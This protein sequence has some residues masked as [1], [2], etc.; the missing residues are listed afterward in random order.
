MPPARSTPP[1]PSTPLLAGF[2]AVGGTLGALLGGGTGLVT[3]PVLDR[4]TTLPRATAHGTATFP[5]MAVALI[6]SLVYWLRGGAIDLAAGLPLMA[7]GVLGAFL[8]ARA[9]AH[10]PE[11][12]LRIVFI[13]VLVVAGAKLLTDA[14]GADP[15]DG[16]GLVTD[17][18]AVAVPV[19]FVCGI[20][21]GAYSAALGLGGGMLTVP[22]LVLLFGVGL[23]AA[24]GTSLL[25]MLPNAVAGAVAHTRQGTAHVGIGARLAAG[26]GPGAVAG[27]S[28][29]LALDEA[30]L[31]YV[32][33]VFVLLMAVREVYRAR[34]GA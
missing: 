15:L 26:A 2:G 29:A 14:A 13:A 8:G 25:V 34:G 30:V 22:A 6:G 18:A 7:G 1:G 10:A 17:A 28:L 19:A 3:V 11:R 33:G 32:F 9:A 5:N 12:V 27:A 24:E 31:G 4:V 20:V 23:H 16:A 21:I